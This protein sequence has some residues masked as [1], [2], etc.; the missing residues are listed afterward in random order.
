VP[1]RLALA[2]LFFLALDALAFRTGWY[3]RFLDPNSTAGALQATLWYEEDRPLT[4]ARQVLAVGDSRMG[5]KARTANALTPQTGLR[6]GTI[7]VP[8]TTPRCWYYMLREVDPDCRR[9]A[10]IVIGLDTYDDRGYENMNDRELDINYLTPL[11]GFADLVPFVFSYQ[12]RPQRIHAAEAV[13]LK[14]LVYQHDVQDFLARP[15]TRVQAVSWI[16]NEGQRAIYNAVWNRQSLEGMT[17]DYKT[18]TLTLPAWV[19]AQHRTI[20][21]DLLLRD[22][23]EYFEPL[24]RY[25]RRWF[26]AILERYRGSKTK[27]IFLQLPRGPAVRP[28]LVDDRTSSVREFAA[29]GRA[30]LMNEH[31]FDSLERPEL[32][33]DAQH[34]NETGGVRFSAMVAEEVS[35]MLGAPGDGR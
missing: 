31:A 11:V 30:M 8:G 26:G 24:A 18:R 1:A 20:A 7:A 15:R 14:G 17:I 10:A 16:R 5:L 29:Q 9:Y 28:N 25:R 13:L 19:D 6:F 27:I 3:L 2:L 33:G 32:F 4:D 21:Q 12:S 35:R 34:L 22:P 23:A